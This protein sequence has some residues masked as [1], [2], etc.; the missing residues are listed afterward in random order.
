MAKKTKK[1]GNGNGN[2]DEEKH[3][4]EMLPAKTD[5]HLPAEPMGDPFGMEGIEGATMQSFQIPRRQIVQP[6]TSWTESGVPA[7]TFVSTIDSG[8]TKEEIKGVL[9]RAHPG[10]VWFKEPTDDRP[11]CGSDD[12]LVPSARFDNPPCDRCVERSPKG[13][14]PV[15]PKSHW[16]VKES[17]RPDPPDCSA[18]WNLLILDLNSGTPFWI[19]LKGTSFVAAKSLFT[20]LATQGAQ[21]KRRKVCCSSFVLDLVRRDKPKP[22]YVARFGKYKGLTDSQYA[23]VCLMFD[24]FRTETLKQDVQGEPAAKGASPVTGKEDDDFEDDSKP[25]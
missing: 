24:R 15:C 17:G 11:S 10:R 21:L 20:S 19:S 4:D 7:G 3:E 13:E 18:T 22:Y 14:V 9:L 1:N 5:E 12:G 25:I 8:D 16:G 6:A 2:G 23:E